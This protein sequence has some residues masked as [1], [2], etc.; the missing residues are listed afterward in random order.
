M[1][2]ASV[3]TLEGIGI[4]SYHYVSSLTPLEALYVR[5]CRSTKGRFEAGD[6]KPLGVDLVKDDQ[7]KVRNI[8]AKLLA[9]QS[10]QKKR[11]G[12][13]RFR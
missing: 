13:W 10:R 5:R 12:T 3:I 11:R 7:D 9:S 4:S 8:Q 1:L 6:A 2:R